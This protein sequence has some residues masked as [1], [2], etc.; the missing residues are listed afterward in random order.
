MWPLSVAACQLPGPRLV[1]QPF[2]ER[3]WWPKKHSGVLVRCKRWPQRWRRVHLMTI[4]RQ[5]ERSLH[6]DAASRKQT[7]I[8]HRHPASTHHRHLDQPYHHLQHRGTVLELRKRLHSQQ[9]ASQP[10][11]LPAERLLNP[12]A[13]ESGPYLTPAPIAQHPY[14]SRPTLAGTSVRWTR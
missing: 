1:L 11:R 3:L 5:A 10:L 9:S 7:N 12:Q 6:G 13:S 14:P 2:T 4:W 8:D